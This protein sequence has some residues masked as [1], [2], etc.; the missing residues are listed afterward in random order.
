[1]LQLTQSSER[2]FYNSVTC[3]LPLNFHYLQLVVTSFCAWF[4]FR[5][6]PEIICD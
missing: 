5:F 2:R 3:C 1:M 4:R 6:R